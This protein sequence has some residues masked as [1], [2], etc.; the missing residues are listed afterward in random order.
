MLHDNISMICGC[1]IGVG[2]DVC[3]KHY[4]STGEKQAIG[5][6]RRPAQRMEQKYPF[7]WASEKSAPRAAQN[8][9]IKMAN[10]AVL[11][12]LTG[13]NISMSMPP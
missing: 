8:G 12:L 10:S 3:L 7:N 1:T 11:E 9:I 4:L 2:R 6:Q 13:K 5:K